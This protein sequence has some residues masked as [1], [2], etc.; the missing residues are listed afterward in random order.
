MSSNLFFIY[1]TYTTA[2]KHTWFNSEAEAN[3]FNTWTCHTIKFVY[4]SLIKFVPGCSSLRSSLLADQS[5]IIRLELE[6]GVRQDLLLNLSLH[7][8]NLWWTPSLQDLE[9]EEIKLKDY[10]KKKETW[11][12]KNSKEYIYKIVSIYTPWTGCSFLIT[13]LTN[14]TCMI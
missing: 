14:A 7:W 4:V 9:L 13:K 8:N 12:S 10:L 3:T 1:T 11:H 5:I 6:T 2:A